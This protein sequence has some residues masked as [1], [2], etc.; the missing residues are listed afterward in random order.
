[1][2]S[3]LIRSLKAS[4]SSRVRESDLAMTGTTLTTSESFLSTTMSIGLRLQ[5]MRIDLPSVVYST[6]QDDLRMTRWLDEEQAAVYTCILNIP[7]SLGRKFF[8]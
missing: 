1:M 4:R 7:L 3:S 6:W 8:S 5:S 2:N